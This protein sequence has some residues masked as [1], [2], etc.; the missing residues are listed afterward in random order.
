MRVRVQVAAAAATVLLAGC[1]GLGGGESPKRPPLTV[2][3]QVQ[4]IDRSKL[5]GTW[6]CH[7]LNP[8]PE[9]PKQ[10]TTIT[11]GKDGTLSGVGQSEARPPFAAMTVKITGK[12]AVEGDQI[13]T[14]DVKT[15]AGSADEFTN[16]MAGIGSSIVNTFSKSQLQG[17]GD[18]LELTQ[19][20]LVFRG[21]G[22]EDPPTYSCTR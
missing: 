10:Q 15:E 12:W 3:D 9:V 19:H 11:Y 6:Q 2:A 5:I 17:S 16:V 21:V 4:Q 20:K 7:E 1:S 8:Y 22:V 13:T 14:S 18:V